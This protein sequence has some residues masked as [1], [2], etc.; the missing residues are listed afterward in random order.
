MANPMNAFV[1]ETKDTFVLF[2][3]VIM[4]IMVLGT[5]GVALGM[6]DLTNQIINSIALGVLL[7]LAIPSTALIIFI[8]WIIKKAQEGSS[9]F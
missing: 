2:L 9:Y 6:E 7:I 3:V 5:I 1:G 8:I 4:S